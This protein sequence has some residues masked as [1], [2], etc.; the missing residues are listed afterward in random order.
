MLLL[1]TTVL[2]EYFRKQKKEK[3]FFFQLAG[4]YSNLAI[5]S[6]TKYEIMVG[7]SPKQ[8]AFWKAL[9]ANLTVIDF[10]DKEADETALICKDL[11]KKNKI[12]GFADMAIGA[13]AK[14]NDWEL[15][16]INVKH[17]NRIE[18]LKLVTRE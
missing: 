6:I 2:I 15:A 11:R 18:G 10:G 7:N 9:L 13:T 17:F 16:T 4:K 1:D 12:I 8:E 3:T 5:S 14:V